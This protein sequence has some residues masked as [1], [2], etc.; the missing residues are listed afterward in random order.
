MLLTPGIRITQGCFPGTHLRAPRFGDKLLPVLRGG[1]SDE[2]DWLLE[3]R[4]SRWLEWLEEP[5]TCLRCRL[6]EPEPQPFGTKYDFVEQALQQ[7]SL[8]CTGD[9]MCSLV[10]VE[11]FSA[12]DVY[13]E[14]KLVVGG[15]TPNRTEPIRTHK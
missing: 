13:K 6:S 4:Y 3:V 2:L 10:C 15:S 7:A 11:V 14:V 5:L 9:N 8:A 1:G 12:L